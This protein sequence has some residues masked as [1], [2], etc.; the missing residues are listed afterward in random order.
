M[1]NASNAKGLM[2]NASN[3][4]G[5][6]PTCDRVNPHL[7]FGIA[8]TCLSRKGSCGLAGRFIIGAVGIPGI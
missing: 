8:G 7:A 3:A 5:R 6:R 2:M 1:L 4:K